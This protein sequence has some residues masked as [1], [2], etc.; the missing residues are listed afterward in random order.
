ME[1][2]IMDDK[3][4]KRYWNQ[5]AENWSKLVNMG[6]DIVREYLNNP[7]FFEILPDISGLTGIDIGCGEGYNTRIFARMGANMTAIDISEK[8]IEK[9]R[10]FELE[11]LLNVDYKIASALNIPFGEEHF[12]FA[13]STMAIMDVADIDK[14]LKEV[15]R[16]LKKGGFFQFS[17]T[18]PLISSNKNEWIYDE[19]GKKVGMLLKEYFNE[20]DNFIDKWIFGAAPKELTNSMKKFQIPKFHRTLS[21]WINTLVNAGFTI[22]KAHEPRASE[23][24]IKKYASLYDTHIIPFSLI[25]LCKK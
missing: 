6:Y 17:I 22:E 3:E 16:I 9:A 21:T 13:V 20:D 24:A 7:G 8:L 12:D 23:D 1:L 10:E 14:A 19:N 25:I 2:F 15:Y 4:V 5:N 11:S 18:H